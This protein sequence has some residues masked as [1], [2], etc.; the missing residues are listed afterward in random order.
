MIERS[1]DL[2]TVW[3]AE[4]EMADLDKAVT[5]DILELRC[6]QILPSRGKAEVVSYTSSG[7]RRLRLGGPL[8]KVY[9]VV[10]GFLETVDRR[11]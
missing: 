1:R 10:G 3:L 4:F 8:G 11:R 5:R 2:G 7:A 9:G 6:E